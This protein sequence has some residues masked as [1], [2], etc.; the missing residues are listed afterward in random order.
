M[1]KGKAYKVGGAVMG[2]SFAIATAILPSVIPQGWNIPILTLTGVGI[3]FGVVLWVYGVKTQRKENIQVLDDIK[4]DLINVNACERKVANKKTQKQ[5]AAE[6]T[7]KLRSDFSQYIM[8]NLPS[9]LKGFTDTSNK[10]RILDSLIRFFVSISDIMD[11]NGYGLKNDLSNCT[12]YTNAREDISRKQHRLNKKRKVL[13]QTN[14]RKVELLTY[15]LNSAILFRHIYRS[16]P[17][18]QEVMPLQFSMMME[19]IER[20][21]EKLLTEMLNNLDVDWV[22]IIKIDFDEI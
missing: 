3:L 9:L 11:S 2:V 13:V 4:S 21:A 6:S 16:V 15:G 5:Y 17:K 14:I 12:T 20:V 7:K 22:K 18:I 10:E 19:S 1:S 8:G